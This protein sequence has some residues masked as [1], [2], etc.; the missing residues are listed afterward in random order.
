[1]YEY[2]DVS[3]VV[4]PLS[5]SDRKEVDLY[6]S[7]PLES[8]KGDLF[9]NIVNKANYIRV[10]ERLKPRLD[11]MGNETVLEMGGG[12]CWA[13]AIIKRDYPKCYV[14][15]SDLGP[16]AVR[17]AEKYESMLQVSIDE[18]WAFNCRQVPF[19]DE[20]F[21][22]VFAFSAFHHFGKDRDFSAAIQ[23]MV[24][25]VKPAGKIMLLHEPS[26]P[27]WIYQF[28]FERVNRK[29]ASR[30]S[31]TIDEDVLVLSDLGRICRQLNCRFEA[32]YFTGYE[33]R[34][35]IV[36]TIYYYALA[37]LKPL[38]RLLPC[39]VNITIEKL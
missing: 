11:L 36:E 31:H 17:F 4:S 9:T 10:F 13:S 15:A 16:E 3:C 2:F 37:R 1:V 21:D 14:V 27:R 35:G 26:S 38:R 22:R 32:Q 39:T 24:R 34:E 19:D 6:A 23:E 28:A 25:I 8:Y 20:Q 18:K 12:H 29:R 33:E 5:E 7:D 30:Y